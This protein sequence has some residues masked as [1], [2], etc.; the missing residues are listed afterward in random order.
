VSFDP[1]EIAQMK[2]AFAGL[3]TASEGGTDFIQIPS[4]QLPEGCDP[5]VV[6]ALFCPF[7]R[8]GYTSRLYLSARI[9]HRGLGQNWN[10]DQ[11][12][13]GR[14]WFA[15]SWRVIESLSRLLAILAAHLEAFACK[16]Q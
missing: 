10:A 13:L 16:P 11:F 12:I 5:P 8:D 7:P 14:R 1:N 6:D 9:S 15:V 3:S 4:L 2:A